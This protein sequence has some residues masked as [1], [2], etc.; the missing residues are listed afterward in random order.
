MGVFHVSQIAQNGTKSR[1][2]SQMV[3]VRLLMASS[4]GL[5]PSLVQSSPVSWKSIYSSRKIQAKNFS[6]HFAVPQLVKL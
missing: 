5:S 3:F 4:I 6:C 1:K 2:A